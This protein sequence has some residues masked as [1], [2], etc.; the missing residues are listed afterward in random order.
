MIDNYTSWKAKFISVCNYGEGKISIPVN[1]N[2]RFTIAFAIFASDRQILVEKWVARDVNFSKP[3]TATSNWNVSVDT[4]QD[5]NIVTWNWQVQSAFEHQIRKDSVTACL[6]NI[7]LSRSSLAKRSMP[8]CSPVIH[9][10]FA[11]SHSSV[12][13]RL[14]VCIYIDF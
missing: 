3:C 11:F 7:W 2:A 8:A 10:S 4:D 14:Y 12:S 13:G 6:S 9:F 1:R 5:A